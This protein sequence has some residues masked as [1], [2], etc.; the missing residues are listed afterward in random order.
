MAGEPAGPEAGPIARVAVDVSLPH[1]DRLFDYRVPEKFLALARPGV[2]CRVRFAGRLRD[3]FIVEL[4]DSS[5]LEA[6]RLAPLE[7]VSSAEVVLH[8]GVARLVRAVADHWAGTFADVARLAVPP[9]H[10]ATETAEPPRY[11]EP[12][13]QGSAPGILTGPDADA[14]L[15]ALAAG[16]NIRAAWTPVPVFG[17]PGDWAGGLVDAARATLSSGRAVILVVPDADAVGVLAA[18]CTEAFGAGSFVV[19]SADLGPAPRY[20]AFLAASRGGVRLVVG[21]RSAV[22]APVRDLGLVAVWDEGSDAFA[23]PRAPYP[24]TREVAALRASLDSCGLLLAGYG[25][26]AETQALVERGWLG[27]LDLPR[28]ARRRA[29]PLARVATDHDVALERDPNARAARLP[30]DAFVVIRAGLASGPVLLQVPR[31]GYAA[32]VACARCRA[33][34]RC[35][36]CAQPVRGERSP[37]GLTLVCPSCGPLPPGWACPACGATGLRAPRVGVARTAEE[38]ARAFPGVTVV[39]SWS[40][41]RV[42]TVGPDP[43]L[44]LATPGTEPLPSHGYSAAVLLDAGVLLGRPELRAAEEALRRWLTAC[45]LVRPASAGGTVLAVGEADSRALQALVRLDATG[46]AERE[47]AE[48]RETRFPPAAKLVVV[49]GGQAAVQELADAAA[50]VPGVETFGPLELADDR[51]RTTLRAEP[52]DAASALVAAVANAAA[53][54]SARKAPGA[55]RVRVDPWVVD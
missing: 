51:W 36:A 21:T 54:R 12:A 26:S 17:G 52:G 18:R 2:R 4:T 38:I 42:A 35:P 9:R 10:A 37:A 25:R 32:S 55:V 33:T 22:F 44:V 46:F 47:L 6:G 27:S 15:A 5:D 39:E 14:W 30:H 29:G 41:H 3:G 7:R 43:A 50:A 8:P 28:R 24:H 20:R 16:R 1:L 11:P 48:R 31:A 23:E 19:L 34:A 53:R 13:L 45:A 49:D 40:A